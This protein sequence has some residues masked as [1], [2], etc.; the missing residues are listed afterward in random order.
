MN[1]RRLFFYRFFSFG[2]ALGLAFPAWAANHNPALSSGSVIML[3]NPPADSP[4]ATVDITWPH[5]PTVPTTGTLTA[6]IQSGSDKVSIINESGDGVTAS[7]T[8]PFPSSFQIRAKAK[9]SAANDVVLNINHDSGPIG[10][11]TLTVFSAVITPP[12]DTQDGSQS[13]AFSIAIEP[14]SVTPDSY[15]WVYTTPSGA[16]R[17]PTGDI[18]DDKTKADPKV[19]A[20]QWFAPTNS[21][22]RNTD[23]PVCKYKIKCKIMIQSVEYVTSEVDWGVWAY[24][25]QV[26]NVPT[27]T[28]TGNVLN[29][30]RTNN[31]S[32][33]T[34]IVVGHNM[35]RTAPQIDNDG[36]L[37]S[38]SFYGKVISSHEGRHVTQWTSVV[39][40]SDYYSADKVYQLFAGETKTGVLYDVQSWTSALQAKANSVLT[41]YLTACDGQKSATA[42]NRERDAHAVSNGVGPAYLK[43]YSPPEY[44]NPQTPLGAAPVPVRN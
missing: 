27:I 19:G 9:S 16:G 8:S 11:K 35:T 41:T 23:G 26:T 20:A 5:D 32:Q 29:I 18:F 38:N 15:E 13:S 14:S 1:V 25:K 12:V 42:D 31:G 39:P 43:A 24:R 40:W 10:S 17:A 36:M 44:A 7:W 4:A 3:S 33:Y 30:T 28:K 2:L 37:S 21:D 34:A 22:N 6:T